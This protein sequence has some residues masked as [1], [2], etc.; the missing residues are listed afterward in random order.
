MV[1]VVAVV[2]GVVVVVIF[3]VGEGVGVTCLGCVI[4]SSFLFSSVRF[5]AKVVV[6]VSSTCCGVGVVV[7]EFCVVS[8]SESANVTISVVLVVDLVCGVD[9]II[10]SLHDSWQSTRKAVLRQRSLTLSNIVPSG[11]VIV[12]KRSVL[13]T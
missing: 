2:V 3:V 1:G 10:G 4:G 12:T 6:V 13:H 8:G 5:S 11:H 9:L 7:G